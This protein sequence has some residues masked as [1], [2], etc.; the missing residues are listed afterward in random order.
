MIVCALCGPVPSLPEIE[1]LIQRYFKQVIVLIKRYFKQVIVFIDC[2]EKCNLKQCS[3]VCFREIQR[4][5]LLYVL[6][7]LCPAI[8]TILL[9]ARHEELL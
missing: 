4:R 5:T 9:K 8:V 3:Q 1:V 6:M 7:V 2:T